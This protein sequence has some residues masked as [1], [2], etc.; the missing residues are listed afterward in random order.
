MTKVERADPFEVSKRFVGP[1]LQND[2]DDYPDPERIVRKIF[3]I[4]NLKNVLLLITPSFERQKDKHILH[5]YAIDTKEHVG[6]TS[7]TSIDRELIER[8]HNSS[9]YSLMYCSIYLELKDAYMNQQIREKIFSTLSMRSMVPVGSFYK[10]R[11]I[12]LKKPAKR[13]LGRT[14]SENSILIKTPDIPSKV[15]RNISESSILSPRQNKT[16][17]G[18]CMEK[19]VKVEENTVPEEV[20]KES[21]GDFPE[22][23]KNLE[24]T[25]KPTMEDC[26]KA[27]VENKT[28][29]KDEL[30]RED[31]EQKMPKMIGSKNDAKKEE[32]RNLLLKKKEKPE[33]KSVKKPFLT[34]GGSKRD[35]IKHNSP[36]VDVPK[37]IALN[38]E[39]TKK[40][41]VQ[42]TA[43]KSNVTKKYYLK[44]VSPKADELNCEETKKKPVKISQPKLVESKKLTQPKIETPPK[45]RIP[46]RKE[47]RTVLYKPPDAKLHSYRFDPK[48]IQPKPFEPSLLPHKSVETKIRS[49]IE[50]KLQASQSKR[51]L[52]EMDKKRIDIPAERIPAPIESMKLS[53]KNWHQNHIEDLQ[54]DEHKKV[55]FHM[56]RD[57]NRQMKYIPAKHDATNDSKIP[58]RLEA[59][60]LKTP[61]KLLCKSTL[62]RKRMPRISHSIASQHSLKSQTSTVPINFRRRMYDRHGRWRDDFKVIVKPH[63]L[64]ESKGAIH[65]PT[66][67][68]TPQVQ[69]NNTSSVIEA[70]SSLFERLMEPISL[71]DHFSK[72]A[73]EHI[74]SRLY[75]IEA[76]QAFLKFDKLMQKI[77]KCPVPRYRHLMT[78]FKFVMLLDIKLFVREEICWPGYSPTTEPRYQVECYV[79]DDRQDF[80][81]SLAL[82]CRQ[83]QEFADLFPDVRRNLRYIDDAFDLTILP[84]PITKCLRSIMNTLHSKRLFKFFAEITYDF[85][86]PLPKPVNVIRESPRLEQDEDVIQQVKRMEEALKIVKEEYAPKE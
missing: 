41:A 62:A 53:Q 26:T 48:I 27:E 1:H 21:K 57:P 13:S 79:F 37:R 35:D 24:I 47:P 42:K 11:M 55:N 39:P 23:N 40:D 16:H 73:C 75:Q 12:T 14:S 44:K 68:G 17:F 71:P 56:P 69:F 72:Q 5:G 59:P 85:I 64:H 33:E 22:T 3:G 52:R 65:M 34:K 4:R 70:K 84:T 78:F 25:S 63:R 6:V 46:K 7:L 20:A 51:S 8:F 61:K 49:I 82:L 30:K 80:I 10:D 45:S 50:S 60:E 18:F 38:N 54:T 19:Y 29:A 9:N 67:S 31:H 81:V 32:C 83:L 76:K 86:Q 43:P 2:E 58:V 36:Q 28:D 66:I 15:N 74:R 77:N